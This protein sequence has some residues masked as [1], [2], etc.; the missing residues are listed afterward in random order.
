LVIL[1]SLGHASSVERL[2]LILRSEAAVTI[3][4]TELSISSFS[5]FK[6]VLT[7]DLEAGFHFFSRGNFP[8]IEFPKF[9]FDSPLLLQLLGYFL[10]FFLSYN[11]LL[12]FNRPRFRLLD[13]PLL[14]YLFCFKYILDYVQRLFL[15]F[16][17]LFL[18][19]WWVFL[20]DSIYFLWNLHCFYL[21]NVDIGNYY[22]SL[23]L[24]FTLWNSL[25]E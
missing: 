13:F 6:L 19:V 5:D 14:L 11:L 9:L 16:G 12:L 3:N 2:N 18:L 10:L 25:S 8:I 7:I 23:Y 4:R 20:V 1:V 17:L 15:G 21:L 24:Y 22:N